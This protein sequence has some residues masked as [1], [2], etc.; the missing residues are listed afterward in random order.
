MIKYKIEEPKRE[1]EIISKDK[2][3]KRKE[4]LQK[5]KNEISKKIKINNKRQILSIEYSKSKYIR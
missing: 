3:L 2:L 5:F 4:L 1:I